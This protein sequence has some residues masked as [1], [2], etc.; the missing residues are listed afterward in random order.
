M[1]IT[2]LN[3]QH[4]QLIY[5][6]LMKDVNANLFLLD[7]LMQYGVSS[8]QSEEW[9]GVLSNGEL[10]ALSVSFG[11]G[12]INTP[13]RL[14]FACGNEQACEPL[15]RIEQAAGGSLMLLGPR[16]AMDGI[17]RGMGSPIPSVRFDQR[18][19]VCTSITPGPMLQLRPADMAELDTIC[20]YNAEM[21]REDLGSD[22]QIYDTDNHRKAMS[23]RIQ[24]EKIF[25]GLQGSTICFCI[26]VGTHFK[27]GAQVGSTFVPK[28][29]RGKGIAT[30]GMRA[31]CH[32]LLKSCDR[33]TLHVNEANVRA[34]R[35]YERSGFQSAAPYR[36]LSLSPR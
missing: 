17:W 10:V 22:P 21:M 14:I 3:N 5:G 15:G 16:K 18:L 12:P 24:A 35:V 28:S 7:I 9:R 33:V 27:M 19:Y 11:R 34:I 1:G 23:K 32:T 6:L 25:V 8:I 20:T 36:L 29:F 13:S 2:I 26:D 31:T 30:Q 4:R